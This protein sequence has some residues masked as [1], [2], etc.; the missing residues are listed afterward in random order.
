MI[1][2]LMLP[3]LSQLGD[4]VGG[5]AQVVKGYFA[6]LSEFDIELVNPDATSYDVKAVH[7]GMTG[8][9]CTCAHMHGIYFTADYN[10][11]EWEWRVNSRVID[12]CRNAKVITVPSEYVAE[13]FRRDMRLNPFI[14]PHGIDWQDWQDKQPNE[15]YILW[16][17]TRRFDVCDNSIID[18]LVRRFPDVQFV[19]TLITPG[20]EGVPFNSGM[21]P[22]NFKIIETG[23]KTPHNK[24]RNFVQRA[25]IYLSTTRETF[26]IGTLEAM[27][28]GVPILGW[29]WGGNTQLV[30][31]GVNGYLAKP[32]DI[33]DLCEGLN[34]CL[35]HRKVLGENSRELAKYWTWQKACEIVAGVY[36]LALQDEQP[37]VSIVIPAYNKPVE[38]IKRAIDSVLSQTYKVNEIVVVNDGSEDEYSLPTLILNYQD[39]YPEVKYFYQSNQGVA[40][41]RNNGI[42]ITNSKYICCLDA[43]DWVEHD[44]IQVCI[45]ALEKE[46]SLGIAYTSI[47]AY[48]NDGNSTISPWP[49][50]FNPDKQLNYPKMNQVPTCCVFRREAWQRVGGYKSR[51]APLGAGSEDA[52]LWSAI[53]SIGYNAKKVT[54]EPLF[55]YSMHGGFVHDNPEY[56][57]IDWL[58]MMPWAKDGQHPFASVATPK[59]YS[60]PVRQ[61]DQPDIS[62][63]IPVGPGHE[64]EVA[65]ALD[66]LEMQHFR[67]WE[68]IVID[69]TGQITTRDDPQAGWLIKAYPYVRFAHTSNRGAGYARNRGV[70]LA[71]APLLF[72]LDADD[73]LVDPHAFDKI[74]KAW[75]DQEAIVYSD[76][77]GKAQWDYDEALKEFGDKL[78]SYNTKK[79]TAVFAKQSAD[80]DPN[81]AQK[82]PEHSG[83]ANM[84]YYHWCL[85]SVLIPKAWHVAI[86]GFDEM[87]ETWEDVDYIWRLARAGY[88]FYRVKD[89]LVMYNYHKGNRREKSAVTDADSLQKHKSLIQYI[90]RKYEGLE[91][92]GCNCGAKRQTPSINGNQQVSAM[93]D[94]DWVM[95]EFDFPGSETRSSYGKALVSPTGQL[96]PGSNQKMEY[97]GYSRKRGDRFLVHIKD[98]QARPNM[99]KLVNEINAPE[100]EREPLGEPALLVAPKRRG[101]QKVVA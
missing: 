48:S 76:Y 88:C 29:A 91:V 5:I 41:A 90:K 36:R 87:M 96:R 4:Q 75:V 95:I 62:V 49:T 54:D 55:N 73:V 34:Y 19:S 68:A 79:G 2:V 71:R 22:K 52:A 45:E 89:P 13:T 51:Y 26:G 94:S 65:N 57:E 92:V 14:I 99:F 31:T 10:A 53:C 28:S 97:A 78:L 64:K 60:H 33:D 50:A 77:L 93:S 11:D 20:L 101:R 40:N 58:S 42:F 46:K 17:K 9:D 81:L 23:G 3:H 72:F 59:R 1:K 12:A 15:G 83:M 85:I 21:W 24:M 47:R 18:I 84:P 86:G 37:T 80:Y 66:S 82:Q 70:E 6:H 38:Q 39:K 27:A 43:D 8:G 44:F 61:Y 25:G 98:Q 56:Q 32:N 7:A 100:V 67:K 16:N 74:L 63:I 69:D 30:Q 35:K